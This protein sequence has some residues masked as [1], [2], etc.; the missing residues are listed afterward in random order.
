MDETI[1]VIFKVQFDFALQLWFSIVYNSV[2]CLSE[3]TLQR[4]KPETLLDY[5]DIHIVDEYLTKYRDS[6]RILNR[7]IHKK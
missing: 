1:Y 3:W 6:D 7:N 2:S 5:P 4:Q